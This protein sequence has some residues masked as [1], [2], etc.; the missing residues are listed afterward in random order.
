MI[1]EPLSRVLEATGYL[2]AG[3]PAA[4]SVSLVGNGLASRLRSLCP[5]AVWR[6]TTATNMNGTSGVVGLS[7]FFKYADASADGDDAVAGWQQEVWNHGFGALLW[8]VWADRIEV[9]NGFGRPRAAGEERA[10]LLGTFGHSDADL[11][12]LDAFAGRLAMETGEF[13]LR[14]GHRVDRKTGVD[15]QLLKDLSRLERDLV[16]ADLDHDEAQGLIGRTV[17]AQYLIDREIVTSDRLHRLCGRAELA[18]ILIDSRAAA[19]LFGWLR[20]RFNGDMFSPLRNR[21][22]GTVHMRRVARFLRAVDPDT[23]Q[24]SLFPYRFDVIPVELISSIYESF[25]HSAAAT[26]QEG[27]ETSTTEDVH[28]TP[29]TAVSM[30]LD[31]VF[32]GLTGDET[33][34]DLT[35]GSGVFLVEALRRLVRLKAGEQMPDRSTIRGVL[36]EQIYGVDKSEAA[37][38]IAAFSLYLAALELDPDPTDARSLGFEPLIGH[39]LLIGDARTIHETEDGRRVLTSGSELKRFDVVVGNPPW[40][41]AGK[42]STAIR[43]RTGSTTPLP[44]RGQGFDFVHRGMDFAHE[45][46]RFG[47]FVSALPFFSRSGTGAKAARHL[48][49]L[50]GS[51]TLVNLSELS[52]WLFPR[53]KMPA[54]AV[55]ARHRGGSSDVMQLVHV[56]RSLK[57][58]HSHTIDLSSSS[59]STLPV[60]SWMRNAGLCK[61]AFFG[62]KHDLLLVDRLGQRFEPLKD[63]LEAL[64]SDLSSGLTFG[65]QRN[66]T[67][68][69]SFLATLPLVRKGAISHFTISSDLPRFDGKP[70]QWPRTRATYRAPSVILRE[71]VGGG[72]GDARDGRLIVAAS[73]EDVVFT[74]TYFGASLASSQPSIAHLIAGILSSALASWHFLMTGSTFG[75]WKRR[76]LVGDIESLPAPNLRDA[77]KTDA[78]ARIIGLVRRFRGQAVSEDDWRALDDAVF[79]LYELNEE[80]RNVALDG[81]TRASWE[82]K[83]GRDGSVSPADRRDLEIY[84]RGFMLSMDSWMYAANA[85]RFS[86]E[87]FEFDQQSPLKVVRFALED[88][89][90][91]STHIEIVRPQMTVRDLLDQMSTKSGRH[92]AKE[93]VGMRELRIHGPREVV[94]VKPAARRFWLGVS[95][96][97]DA[98]VVMMESVRGQSA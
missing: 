9:Y 38:R 7:A 40:S 33:V 6:S 51:V 39:T 30:V 77:T 60:A 89:P 56:R 42:A 16:R 81:R 13:W 11:T 54:M 83:T 97:D 12:D 3:E 10:N 47:V 55:M 53:A 8:V 82:W 45:K 17:F 34:I 57:G 43:R 62:R 20:E 68:K 36:Y 15:S 27:D 84:C 69:A 72:W 28:Y 75:L 93:L 46:T 63:E 98:R 25:V 87:I 4:P 22:P 37:V 32:C 2:V 49:E 23:G 58:D 65:A 26:Q 52:R 91:P 90:P 80:E 67:R 85:R 19:R 88:Y 79:D 66:R 95:G 86:A 41:Y 44:P 14:H 31:Q 18:D 92:I 94:V 48:I 59:A 71:Y 96:M 64:G 70:V 1:T 73:G 35:C 76:L 5:D 50:L 29:L 61:A 24:M 21:R 78:G 74:N